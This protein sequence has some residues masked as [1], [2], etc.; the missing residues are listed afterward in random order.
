LHGRGLYRGRLHY[1]YALSCDVG[2]FTT[3]TGGGSL[4]LNPGSVG[5]PLLSRGIEWNEDIWNPPWAEYL[6][7]SVD[8]GMLDVQFRRFPIDV[9]AVLAAAR[10]SGMPRVEWWCKD[11]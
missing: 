4:L 8:D 7:L 5:L 9:A 1:A 2:N 3:F 10:R 11:W 6:L